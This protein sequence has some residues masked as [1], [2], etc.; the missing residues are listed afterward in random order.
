MTL[1]PDQLIIRQPARIPL[2][3]STTAVPSLE[4]QGPNMQVRTWSTKES[5]P[6]RGR[7]PQSVGQLRFRDDLT[8][9]LN[10]CTVRNSSTQTSASVHQPDDLATRLGFLGHHLA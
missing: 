3:A 2:H 8:Y 10:A 4:T 6:K 7:V 5:T 9:F 1:T